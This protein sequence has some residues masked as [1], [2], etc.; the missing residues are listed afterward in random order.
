VIVAYEAVDSEGRTCAASVEASDEHDAR[1][2]LRR[3]GL[4]VT[5]VKV[6]KGSG[7]G[8]A[9]ERRTS[10]EKGGK[11]PLRVLTQMTRHLSML[12]R[13]GS[14]LVPSLNAIS[15]QMKKPAHA[16][17]VNEII[18]E[19]EDG[20]PL[21]E[22][23][24]A[25]PRTFGP[26]YTAIIAAGEASGSLSEM[27]ERLSGIVGKARTLRKKI[28]G[29]LAYPAVLIV[30]SCSIMNVLL[31]FV[32][33]RFNVMFTQLGVETPTVTKALLW[34]GSTL[35]SGWP[36]IVGALVMG[37]GGAVFALMR[38]EGKQWLADVQLR[39]PIIGKLRC[40]LILAQVLRT[41]GVLIDSKVGVLDA[42]ALAR[43][44][45]RSRR[46]QD[47]FDGIE[48]CVTSGER[49]STAF[50]R[51]AIADPALCQAVHTG[52]DSGQL[53]GSML[54]CADMADE[55]N[56]ELITLT[57]RLLEPVILVGMGFVVG[58]VAGALFIPLFDITSAIR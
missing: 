57:M 16:A 5:H 30:M 28:I 50:E 37:V 27:L 34:V 38:D 44:S 9:Q 39:V 13:S 41:L 51:S 4:F 46:F 49:M 54:F 20:R 26:V 47:L 12:L 36:F 31:F 48:K 52:E 45:T 32:V 35:K 33:P 55:D 7:A 15:K 58:T 25:H 43:Q 24:R 23:L 2:Q 18:D 42:V 6:A 21:S 53:G 10:G 3:Q 11:L 14:G 29:A 17:I 8:G 56:E 40:Q 1:E 22:A 19:L